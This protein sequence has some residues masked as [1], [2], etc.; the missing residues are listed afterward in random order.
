MK[1]DE[2]QMTNDDHGGGKNGKWKMENLSAVFDRRPPLKSRN[3]R[4]GKW[5]M[6][7]ENDGGLLATLSNRAR[8]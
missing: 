1:N 3:R 4:S 5:K 7:V 6:G 2:T 8:A